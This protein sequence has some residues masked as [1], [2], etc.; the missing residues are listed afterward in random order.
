VII[1]DLI[2]KPYELGGRGPDKYDCAGL[3]VECMRRQGLPLEIPE[4]DA[5]PH[6]GG[7]DKNTAAM[8]RLIRAGWNELAVPSPGCL[9]F[10]KPDHVGVYL[11]AG[12]FLHASEDVGQVCIEYLRASFW[13]RRVGGFYEHSGITG[14][15]A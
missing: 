5:Q 3:V 4:T 11:G 6:G 13:N 10:F 12:R 8:W 2:G 14:G 15:A 9:I 1:T 7:W